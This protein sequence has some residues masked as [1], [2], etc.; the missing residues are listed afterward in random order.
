MNSEE[1][2]TALAEFDAEDFKDFWRRASHDELVSAYASVEHVRAESG[3]F[4]E[5][6]FTQA[7]ILRHLVLWRMQ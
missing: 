5:P 2:K 4:N 3:M 7:R 1:R 6:E